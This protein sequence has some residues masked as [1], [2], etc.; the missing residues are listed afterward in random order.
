MSLLSDKSLRC[1]ALE[2]RTDAEENQRTYGTVDHC[3]C[4]DDA[5]GRVC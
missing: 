3:L 2:R 5:G 1:G 4:A